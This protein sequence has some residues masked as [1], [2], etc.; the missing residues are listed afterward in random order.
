MKISAISPKSVSAQKWEMVSNTRSTPKRTASASS[1]QKVDVCFHLQRLWAPAT[2]RGATMPRWI[3]N[4]A[5]PDRKWISNQ[6]GWKYFS[7]HVDYY[8]FKQTAT[9][10]DGIFIYGGSWQFFIYLWQYFGATMNQD[11]SADLS[12]KPTTLILRVALAFV[13]C[14][15]P[16]RR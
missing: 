5:L 6:H 14:F 11:F 2:P 7:S 10:L 13:S 4:C 1:V 3:P 15:N 9:H 8:T 12:S 16:E